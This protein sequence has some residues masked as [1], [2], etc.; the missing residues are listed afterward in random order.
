MNEKREQVRQI[1]AEMMGVS[2]SEVTD[3]K[4]LEEDLGADSLDKIETLMEIEDKLDCEVPNEEALRWQ[5]VKDVLDRFAPLG[6][7]A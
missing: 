6:A 2:T 1:I 4:T 5:T 3:E 7:P